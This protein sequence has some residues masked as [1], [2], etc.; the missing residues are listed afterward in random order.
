MF[1][2]YFKKH[3]LLYAVC[4]VVLVLMVLFTLV[5]PLL[6]GKIIGVGI[7]Q[8]G[9]DCVS[10][11]YITVEG[12]ELIEFILPEEKF[13][14][15][16][17]CY[18]YDDD[19]YEL[20]SDAD[21]ESAVEIYRNFVMCA[22]DF[23][24]QQRGTGKINADR[25]K[26]MSKHITLK[27]FYIAI[28]E[29]PPVTQQ[30]R[31]K[32]YEKA[33]DCEEA[34]KGQMAAIFAPYFY[35][36]AGI[37]IEKTQEEYVKDKLQKMLVFAV[38]QVLC[39]V[40]IKTISSKISSSTAKDMRKDFIL[41]TS[42]FTKEQSVHCRE[43][44][45]DVFS[46][47]IENVE[48]L[49]DYT[50]GSFA[51]APVLCIAGTILSFM[52]SPVL[53]SIV[54]ITVAVAVLI[55]FVLYKVAM[56]RFEKLQ[57]IYYIFY[58]FIKNSVAQIHT[59]RTLGAEKY[60]TRKLMTISGTVRKTEKFV[61]R[62]FFTALS[63]ISL[64][65][66]FVMAVVVIV[67]GEKLLDSSLYIA[68]IIA[69][70]HCSILTVSAFM[71]FGA[72][73]IFIPRAKVSFGKFA[74]VMSIEAPDFYNKKGEKLNEN[75]PHRIE[76]RNVSVKEEG[77]TVDLKNIS[78]TAQPGEITAIVGTT[79]CGK[80]LLLNILTKN[81]LSYTGDVFIDSSDIK[82]I[83]IASIQNRISYADS[84]PVIFSESV[85]KNMILYGAESCDEINQALYDAQ[86]DF[87][88]NTSVILENRA[89]KFSGG[90]RARI[91]LAGA[92]SKKAG[93]Y[94]LDDCMTALDIETE[95][96]ILDGLEKRTDEATIIIVSQRLNT[97]KRADKIVLISGGVVEAVGT[98]QWLLENSELYRD[99]A[100]L[101]GVEVM[102]DET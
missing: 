88:N 10:P 40:I 31:V 18:E 62:A 21:S 87:I 36:D 7:E 27:F 11:E 53:G 85:E 35:K 63:V 39:V 45:F 41:H 84:T 30:E 43:N 22:V 73:I 102:A 28:K 64:I 83:D 95:S 13:D 25:M 89:N 2:K 58:R 79:G 6:L 24:M 15:F 9:I 68:D 47:D 54:L 97:I 57:N 91:A 61:L 5:Q 75:I 100:S 19:M 86:V 37:D 72:M 3:G 26:K 71:I 96:K 81:Y 23:L 33:E 14:E 90:Q 49:I 82:E 8:K 38:L 46:T 4:A 12:M 55:L 48:K 52:I 20:K 101:Q 44:L 56:P 60:Q 59:V 80:S 32:A 29:M 50:I 77:T 76:F 69:F 17:D 99:F 92:L 34:V 98:H 16:C 65:S 94:I 51:Y 66:N 1:G 67:G 74:Y 70:L 93:V 78:F 42:R